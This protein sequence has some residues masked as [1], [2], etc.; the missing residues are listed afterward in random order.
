MAAFLS[1]PSYEAALPERYDKAWFNPAYA[2]ARLGKPMGQLLSA[3]AYELLGVIPLKTEGRT[4]ELA[5]LLEVFLELYGVFVMNREL[6]EETDP[7]EIR[8]I[9]YSFISD[10]AELTVGEYVR[11][12]LVPDEDFALRI[13]KEAD[14]SD[15]ASLEL[16]G[17]Y[18]SEDTKKLF[19]FMN[20]LKDEDIKRMADAF[21]EG[22]RIGFLNT[23]KDL[24][25]KKT[26]ELRFHIGFERLLRQEIKNFE[27]MGLRC[28]LRR[29]PVHAAVR[30]GTEYTGF[31]GDHVNRQMD[32]DHREDKALFLDK[33]FVNRKLEVLRRIYGE[34]RE[35]AGVFAGPAVMET[36]GEPPF[37]PESCDAALTLDEEGRSLATYLSGETG[38]LVNEFIPGDERSFTIISWPLPSIGADFEA[39]FR[40]S[41]KLNTLDYSLYSKLQQKIIDTLERGS[42][43]EVLGR[44]GNRTRLR[45]SLPALKD[46]KKQTIFEN[47]VS[48]VNI[49]VGEVFTSPRLSGT[50]GILSVSEVF[51]NGLR[52]ENL[53]FTFKDGYV[54]D[55][56]C[57]NFSEKEENRHY[58][59]EHIL[60]H[61][62]TLPLGEFAIGTNTRAYAMAKR[63]GIFS[64]LPILIA[65]K[66]GPHFA[67]GDT[68]YSRAEDVRV[69]NPD[70]REI[71]SKDN[72]ETLK[73]K[74]D[75]AFRYYECHTDVTIPYEELGSITAVSETGERF[76]VIA[77]GRFVV[78]GTEMLNEP[79]GEN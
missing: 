67:L 33:V 29:R 28:T 48:D 19:L 5:I 77:E 4:E 6:E 63:Y 70:G 16:Y 59:E 73:R 40:E 15:P 62:K 12:G 61:H 18:V 9:W 68:C 31:Y 53:E 20:T 27:A 32:Y 45:V 60:H 51:L 56:S 26:V 69:Y 38:K 72:E 78:E 23:G 49:P 8:G 43:V 34:L 57:T 44:N 47:C 39:I 52:F 41:V 71:I 75:P 22:F 14:L 46:R 30:S 3:V 2:V 37:L 17:E 74:T 79:L 65:E 55:Y 21:T 42:S 11:A 24:S 25:K 1:D 35:E 10:Y 66:T 54:T 36:F 13:V 50:D 76:P 64:L 58:I 7:K